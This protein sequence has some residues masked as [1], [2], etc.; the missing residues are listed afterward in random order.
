MYNGIGLTTARGSGTNGYVQRN[1]AHVN[2]NRV[3]G[4]TYNS[5]LTERKAPVQRVANTEILE[6]ERKRRIEVQV[7]EWARANGYLDRED[8]SEEALEDLLQKKREQLNKDSRVSQTPMNLADSHHRAQQKEKE[9]NKFRDALGID[10]EYSSGQAFDRNLQE[11]RRK[12]KEQR[13]YAEE[14]AKM[15]RIEQEK[16]REYEERQEKK[17]AIEMEK[18]KQIEFSKDEDKKE[19]KPREDRRRDASPDRRRDDRDRSPDR[20]RRASPDRRR[21][22]S[23]DRR[24]QSSPD[25]R[26][27]ASPDMRR[28]PSPDRRR[29]SRE[30]SP[31]RGRRDSRERPIE[32]RK[33]M[34]PENRKRE[35]SPKRRREESP[36]KRESRS[37]VKRHSRTPDRRRRHQSWVFK[38]ITNAVMNV[39][40]VISVI[41]TFN[42]SSIE[43]ILKK[44][45][46][47]IDTSKCKS[48][49]GS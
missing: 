48:F 2:K 33:D 45:V 49:Q 9:I 27:H 8:L 15:D 12:E 39:Y 16:E 13:R 28:R 17:K 43:H 44:Y 41:K 47:Y 34:S 40:T 23:P 22:A 20:R 26:R 4:T 3:Q 29:D 19:E 25:R 6:H 32:K 5:S 30:R 38:L 1:L 35:S 14:I 31:E 18:L 37:P 46:G 10:K 24:R 11:Q 36:H 21:Q 7:M 42:S